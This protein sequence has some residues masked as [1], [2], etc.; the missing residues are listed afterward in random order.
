MKINIYFKLK[1]GAW[2]GGNQFLKAVREYLIS[3]NAYED[4]Y[5]MADIVLFNSHQFLGDILKIKYKYPSKIFIHRVDGP[6]IHYRGGD[7]YLDL[8]LF[9]IN[10]KLADGTIFQSNYSKEACIKLGLKSNYFETTIINAPN[11]KIFNQKDKI[12]NL[13]GEKIRLVATSWSDNWKKGFDVYEWLDT[14][15]DFNKYEMRFI[16]NTPI[17]FKNIKYIPP[18]NSEDLAKEL[19]KSDIFI[20]ASKKDP[21]SNSLI[22]AIHSGL[23]VIVLNDGGHAEIIKECGKTFD[24]VGE[25]PFLLDEIMENYQSYVDNINLPKM[26]EVGRLYFEFCKNI[27]TSKAYTPKKISLSFFCKTTIEIFF[28]KIKNKLSYMARVK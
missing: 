2:G 18:L 1:D 4:D 28:E 13:Q 9:K 16:G 24:S 14:N 11:P 10:S 25:I 26:N 7:I 6:M 17:K 23:P 15:L 21:C 19:R 27:Y 20:T 12:K 3:I 22:E 8:F 5:I